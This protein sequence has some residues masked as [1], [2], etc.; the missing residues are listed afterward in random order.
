M[1]CNIHFNMLMF[2]TLYRLY[3]DELKVKHP[4]I[5]YKD[6]QINRDKKFALWLKDKVS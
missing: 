4:G 6:I 3:D 2:I 1:T 5:T